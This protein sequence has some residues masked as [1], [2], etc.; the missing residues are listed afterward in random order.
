M[1]PFVTLSYLLIQA[2][3]RKKRV[4]CFK[5]KLTKIIHYIKSTPLRSGRVIYENIFTLETYIFV[6]PT[7]LVY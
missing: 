1:T 6:L 2:G 5:N 4:N 3:V 7:Y